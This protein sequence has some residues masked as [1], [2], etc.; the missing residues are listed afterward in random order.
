M[1]VVIIALIIRYF[2]THY[3]IIEINHTWWIESDIMYIVASSGIYICKQIFNL[4][5]DDYISKEPFKIIIDLITKHQQK[6]ILNDVGEIDIKKNVMF[7]EANSSSSSLISPE[8]QER[9]RFRPTQ[10]LSDD[11][12]FEERWAV[13]ED[14][15]NQIG[16][17]FIY[18]K[19]SETRC[20]MRPDG[21]PA[22]ILSQNFIDEAIEKGIHRDD[23]YKKMTDYAVTLTAQLNGY[24]IS[25]DFSQFGLDL[26]KERGADS[27]MSSLNWKD[28]D[29]I[30]KILKSWGRRGNPS[31]DVRRTE[32][33]VDDVRS[34]FEKARED[35]RRAENSINAIVANNNQFM[36]YKNASYND[37]LRRSTW[38]SISANNEQISISQFLSRY[39][40]WKNRQ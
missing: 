20:L 14:D 5:V 40:A 1:G 4:T 10:F 30:N 29:D 6:Q 36:D 25:Q 26:L 12:P 8:D 32:L 23:I 13:V 28:G 16:T 31:L 33:T 34:V 7:M 37:P 22:V 24:K 9:T 3:N 17:L 2:V 19:V 15:E 11:I 38:V 21:I 39:G 27:K 18:T 35:N